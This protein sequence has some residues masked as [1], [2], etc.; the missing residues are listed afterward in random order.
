MAILSLVLNMVEAKITV[1]TDAKKKIKVSQC[2]RRIEAGLGSLKKDSG[3]VS[4]VGAIQ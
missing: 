2:Q 3:A 4:L 1:V